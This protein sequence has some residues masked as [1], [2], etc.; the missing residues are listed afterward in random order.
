MERVG[1]GFDRFNKKVKKMLGVWMDAHLMFKEY[2]NEY[3]KTA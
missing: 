1:N 3:V 2:H